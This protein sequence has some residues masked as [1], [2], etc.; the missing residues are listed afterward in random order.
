MTSPVEEHGGTARHEALTVERGRRP[1]CSHQPTMA[2]LSRFRQWDDPGDVL[3]DP[4]SVRGAMKLPDGVLGMARRGP[5]WA[6]WVDRLPALVDGLARGVG[7]E[8]GRLDDAR[9]RRAGRAGPYDGRT[10]GRAEGELP[11][12]GV[13]ARAPR[14]AALGRTRCGEAAARRPAPFG[15]A[16]RAA[17]PGAARRPLGRRGVRGRRRSLR[18][19]PPARAA[20]APPAQHVRRPVGRR[21]RRAP[22][23]RAAPSTARRAGGLARRATSRWTP[24]PRAP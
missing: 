12:R 4:D 19:A 15:D 14:A 24:R 20:P 6:A 22:T 17:A 13:G 21:A 3:P 2:Q 5:D 9:L 16:P 23:Q 1:K 7:A 8:H 11:R 18:V 10:T